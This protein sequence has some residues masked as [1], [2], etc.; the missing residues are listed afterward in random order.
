[1][2]VPL[3]TSVF[4]LVSL[5]RFCHGQKSLPVLPD[6]IRGDG[7]RHWNI[8]GISWSLPRVSSEGPLLKILPDAEAVH[9]A[10]SRSLAGC[11]PFDFP[12]LESRKIRDSRDSR[13][14][15][16]MGADFPRSSGKQPIAW[17]T[18]F[19]E[20]RA[21][22]LPLHTASLVPPKGRRRVRV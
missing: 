4:S 22:L 3:C 14:R 20:G 18:S 2:H 7:E 15:L 9:K 17:A 12:A 6:T 1:M 5:S 11:T 13:S 16:A 19:P 10:F 21:R 8:R